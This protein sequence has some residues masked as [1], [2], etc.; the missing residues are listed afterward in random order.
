MVVRLIFPN[1]VAD[2]RMGNEEQLKKSANKLVEKKEPQ[3]EFK[4]T[5]PHKQLFARLICSSLFFLFF[6]N[7][8]TLSFFFV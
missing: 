6:Y 4:N 8:L 7:H 1:V 5:K 3:N 2:F